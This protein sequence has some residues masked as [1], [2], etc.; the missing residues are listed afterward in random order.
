M[1][2]K[3]DKKPQQKSEQ[4][5]SALKYTGIATKMAAIIV[6]G[7]FGGVELDKRFSKEFPLYTLI[8]TIFSVALAMFVVIKD[9]S[10]P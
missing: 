1:Q 10:K 3:Q 8:L 2:K 4:R 7:S 6:V 5:N 9:I